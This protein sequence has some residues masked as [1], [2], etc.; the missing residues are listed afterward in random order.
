MSLSSADLNLFRSWFGF[1]FQDLASSPSL[2][3]H[4]AFIARGSESLDP[5]ARAA[6]AKITKAVEQGMQEFS[7]S[8]LVVLRE[9]DRSPWKALTKNTQALQL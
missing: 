4:L 8:A 5:K 3:H 1:L 2:G 6:S 7:T 9:K